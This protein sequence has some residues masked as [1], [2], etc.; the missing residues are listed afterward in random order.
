MTDVVGEN[1][2]TACSKAELKCSAET[3]AIDACI[4]SPP[5]DMR[6]TI[7]RVHSGIILPSVVRGFSNIR[8]VLEL[9]SKNSNNEAAVAWLSFVALANLRTSVSKPKGNDPLMAQA[10]S[11]TTRTSVNSP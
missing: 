7:S 6:L 11:R 4:D 3:Y 5:L 1:C 10:P 2:F 9:L 8:T